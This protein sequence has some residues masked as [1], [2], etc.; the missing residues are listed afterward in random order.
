MR[1]K[2]T[3]ISS[4]L[5]FLSSTYGLAVQDFESGNY[6]L[7]HCKALTDDGQ[8]VGGVWEGE[9]AG[10]VHALLWLSTTLPDDIKFCPPQGVTARQAERVVVRYLEAH[11]EQLHRDLND[12]ALMALDQA[13][14]CPKR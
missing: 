5:L 9:C 6:M 3:L 12:L 13:W 8:T 11:P 1:L 10:I 7:P 2:L 4:S 14:P